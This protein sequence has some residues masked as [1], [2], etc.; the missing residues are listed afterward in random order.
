ME[1]E[2]DPDTDESWEPDRP[3]RVDDSTIVVPMRMYKGITVFS[4]L[5]AVV[6]VVF[7]FFLFDAATQPTNPIR[8][9]VT[10]LAGVPGF[11]V[12]SGVLDVGF[13]LAGV[14]VILLGAGSYVLGSRFK[15]S[16]MLGDGDRDR[17]EDNAGEAEPTPEA[18]TETAEDGKA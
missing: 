12:P 17:A 14:A 11:G 5:V 16:E 1:A 2:A 8:Q 3:T 18:G 7:G 13:G 6:L 9:F 10:W 4:T 15:T